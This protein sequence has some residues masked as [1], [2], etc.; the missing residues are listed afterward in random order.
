[1]EA[2]LLRLRSDHQ[3]QQDHP[4]ASCQNQTH[5]T[6]QGAQGSLADDFCR[7]WR[8]GEMSDVVLKVGRD[9]LQAHRLVLAVRSPVFKQMLAAPMSE[10]ATGIVEIG[11]MSIEVARLLCEFM[12]TDT[13]KGQE[14]AQ[15]ASVI[16]ELLRAAA[17]YECAGLVQLC[18]DRARPLI[19]V[20][21]STEWITIATQL[22]PQ[23]TLL[24]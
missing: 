6:P 20:E 11:D 22:K 16:S 14:G 5:H 18:S 23:T 2:T 9:E 24:M 3:Q 21:N 10:K 4:S 17:K 8:S 1:M 7:L 15:D 13:I 12:Y 19:A